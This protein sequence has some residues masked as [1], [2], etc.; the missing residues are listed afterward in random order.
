[1][2]HG[3]RV[4]LRDQ[5]LWSVEQTYDT[6][7]RE[8]ITV[9]AFPP[10]YLRQLSD[11]AGVQGKGPGVKTYCFAGEA[12]SREMLH[13]VIRNLQPEWIINGYGPTE[14]V[15]TPTLWLESAEKA[16]FTTA[17]APIGDLVGDRQG[18][19]MDADLNPLP[20]GIA[21]EL[22]LGGAVARGYLDRP[23]ATAERF[24]PH[25][26]RP[27]ERIYRSGD[28]VRLNS[29]GLLEYLGRI[30]HQIKLRGFRIEAG[31]IEAALKGCEGVREA[32]VIVRD[33]P[34]G[35]RLLG[36]VGGNG[37]D[38]DS[39]KRQ[40]KQHLPEYMVPQHIVTLERLPQ[41][42]NGKLDRNA[43]P[44]PQVAASDYEAPQGRGEERLAEVWQAL[45]GVE[46]V[47]R[48]DSFFELGGDSIQSL[49]VISRLR[50]TG[51]KLAPRDVFS[52]PRLKELA[53]CLVQHDIGE[54]MQDE[55]VASGTLPLTPIQ[56]HFFELPMS[57]RAHW[58]QALL[59]DV[60][61]P[62]EA[63]LLEKALDAVLDH[64]NG[65][66]LGFRALADGGWEQ[67]YRP[68]AAPD[69]LWV[70]EVADDAELL[71]LCEQAQ[72][73]FDLENG[74]LLRLVLANMPEGQRLLLTA[75][76]LVVDG[77]SWRVLLE[78]L[79]RAYAQLGAGN[80][81][82]LGPKPT[83]YQRWAMHL[84]EA[85]RAPQRQAEVAR[86]VDLIGSGEPHW[87]VDDPHGSATQADLDQCELELDEAHTRRLL[88]E[89]PA[90]L[91][92]R[93]DEILLA[94]LVQALAG[95]TGSGD[96]LVALEGHGRDVLADDLDIGRTLGWFTTLFPLRVAAAGDIGE[97]L[98]RVRSTLRGLPDKG[99]GFG[100][101]RYLGDESA[102]Q[103]LAALPEPKV[104]FN[105]LGQFD[106]D[107]GD[108]RFAPAPVSA[109]AL[110][111]P[112]TP[113]SRELEINGQVFA[114]RLGLSF[115]FS[116]ARYRRERIE[117]LLTGYRR[118]L[119]ALL[120][121][122]PQAQSV[123]SQP[124]AVSGGAPSPLIRLSRGASG[125][126]PVFCVHPVSGTVV[127]YYALARTLSERWDVWGLQ[128]RQVLDGS[129]RDSSIEQ[130]ARD[131][132]KV[133]LEQQPS[134]PYRLIGWSMGGT[135]VLEMSRLL[136]RLGK[137]V[138]FVGLIDGYVPGAGKPRPAAS[139]P[140]DAETGEIEGDEHWQ[141]LLAVERHMR[142]LANQ[143]R[144]I[145]PS[146]APVHAWWALRSPENNENAPAL[147]EQGMG[148][149]MRASAWIDA[150]HLSIVRDQLF[151]T[152]LAETLA[153]V[154]EQPRLQDHQE[155]EYA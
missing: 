125:Q 50:Q 9:A 10:S 62:L 122:L 137:P 141:Q 89:A 113:L 60:R 90:A 124:V 12:F 140:A 35:K 101:L 93:V 77:V 117:G 153:R 121:N 151:I 8:G 126:P 66:N 147:L 115:R 2:C 4:V 36:Y 133:L 7:I 6:L 18:Y 82:A 128:N 13:D 30:D 54:A 48:H 130:M 43:L 41:L 67:F 104:V 143:C 95:W 53:L 29:Q 86:W 96:S 97:T 58:N 99:A 85:A 145:R 106:R 144:E 27:G 26:F 65:L 47:S 44:D 57:N 73:S 61:Q 11:W 39:L 139:R 105:Y 110:V 123:E 49:A 146:N 103:R 152:Q 21:G 15:V 20:P 98:E 135:L 42:P 80:P 109:G 3:A 150:D 25:P 116:G 69:S 119:G 94:A 23:G 37:L 120:D 33:G 111:D 5:E 102:R 72:R 19:V 28:R 132:V 149:R 1:M 51:W 70:R 24:L 136:E 52:H 148:G 68:A 84:Q 87:P 114:G 108:G 17:Y 74:P 154:D 32:L 38:E 81:L 138:E 131:Y 46:R 63:P 155:Y 55:D 16:D 88:R 129:W 40:L 142:Q 112:A 118:A 45:L 134:G 31:E 34:S 100:L 78:D 107:L 71:A 83:S 14:T 59:L 127:G 56:A 91:Q 79:A 22:Y 92:A 75:H 76:H 64:H